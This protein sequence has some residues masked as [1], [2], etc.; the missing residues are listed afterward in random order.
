MITRKKF[1]ATAVLFSFLTTGLV[2]T[3]SVSQA[4]ASVDGPG[5]FIASLGERAIKTLADTSAADSTRRIQF[6]TL[7]LEGF[8]VNA[9]SRYAIGRYWRTAS[10]SQRSEYQRLFTDFI[11]NTY[12]SRF[13]QYSGEKF[14]VKGERKIKGKK[15]T[16]VQ[17]EII[18]P[19][20]A[21]VRVDWRVRERKSGY[22]VIDIIVEGVS[23]AITQREEFSTVI[24]RSGGKVDGLIAE[25][26]AKTQ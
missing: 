21:P 1:L 9:L 8:D 26:K 10:K 15:D 25:L 4:L 6:R 22:K 14:L 17:S 18:R 3:T 23:M 7:F 2:L 19:Q 5:R 24:R 11:V 12:A 16:I 13:G 20:G